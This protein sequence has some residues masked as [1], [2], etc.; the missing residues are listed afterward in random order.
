M[1][2][3]TDRFDEWLMS[4]LTDFEGHQFQNV[5]KG[6]LDLDG[7]N[8]EDDKEK[9]EKKTSPLTE[10]IKEILGDQVDEVRLSARL[11]DSPACLVIGEHEMGAQMRQIMQ[12]AGQPL[13]PTKP[14]L[15]INP[16]HPLMAG[17]D[18]D[19]PDRQK[20]LAGVIYGQALIS[21]GEQLEDPAEFVHQLNRLLQKVAV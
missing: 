18:S 12:A 17:F 19:D 13:P 21:S 6:E 11:T 15:E 4:Y 9:E 20:D 10:K 1:L 7:D 2:L 16:D 5:A 3:L 14:V 8:S